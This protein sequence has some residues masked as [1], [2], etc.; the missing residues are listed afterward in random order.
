MAFNTTTCEVAFFTSNLHE[1]ATRL[2]QL[3]RCLSRVFLVITDQVQTTQVET[4]KR[5][6]GVCNMP[7]LI[8]RQTAIAYKKVARL[9]PDHPRQR[10]L[11]FPVRHRLVR[12]SW[13]SAA[14]TLIKELS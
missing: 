4:L 14:K 6:A 13:R 10:L 12:P 7:T 2:E 3:G 1:A 11:N 8:R 9:T 5:E